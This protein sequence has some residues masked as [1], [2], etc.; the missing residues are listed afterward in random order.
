MEN[1]T[2]TEI[3]TKPVLGFDNWIEG[4]TS[5]SYLLENE[6][7]YLEDYVKELQVQITF[8]NEKVDYL[9]EENE[10]ALEEVTK[11]ANTLINFSVIKNKYYNTRI[12]TFVKYFVKI[13]KLIK[14]YVTKRFKQIRK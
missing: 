3:K 5:I 10:I 1:T 9:A 2:E 7:K 13:Y 11:Y 4:K 8:L 6:L 14:K 12:Y